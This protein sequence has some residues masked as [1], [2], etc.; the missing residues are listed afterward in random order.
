[1][2]GRDRDGR[3]AEASVIGSLLLMAVVAV[4]ATIVGG[5][6]VA[7][8]FEPKPPAATFE[9]DFEGDSLRLTYVGPETLDG[10]ELALAARSSGKSWTPWS[11]TVVPGESV[12]LGPVD[13]WDGEAVR[14]VWTGSDG[15][16]S[17]RLSG[18]EPAVTPP[19]TATPTP[20]PG[21]TATPTP[22]A[23]PTATTTPTPTPVA[24]SPGESGNGNSG[25]NG[26]G[27][28]GNNGN[29][30]SGNNGNGNSGNNGNGNGN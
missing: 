15:R 22:T 29:G 5:V 1:M 18:F 7:S 13:D 16:R 6:G 11:G 21:G 10:E 19:G 9:A 12:E 28:S 17:T 3:R 30:N 24:N 2:Q 27:N 25:N 20:A 23:A 26:N 4:S 8:V 14:V